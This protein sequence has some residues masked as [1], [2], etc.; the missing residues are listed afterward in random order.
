MS[1]LLTAP[2]CF[3]KLLFFFSYHFRKML[4]FPLTLRFAFGFHRMSRLHT[5][6]YKQTTK[7]KAFARVCVTLLWS[8][9]RL[10]S[11]FVVVPINNLALCV[12]TRKL[13][14]N[15]NNNR[16]KNSNCIYSSVLLALSAVIV[17]A[18][19]DIALL[20][21]TTTRHAS[22]RSLQQHHTAL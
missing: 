16:N 10:D 3:I 22:Q 8:P 19:A 14:N 11:S 21:P 2:M 17:I 5:Q 15:N 6:T 13:H 4:T 20:C 1:A 7:H 9:T 18:N 12:A